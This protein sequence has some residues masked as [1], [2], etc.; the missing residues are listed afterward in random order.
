MQP[1]IFRADSPALALKLAPEHQRALE[2]L[3]VGLH[4]DSF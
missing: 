4:P 3:L 1:Q 2:H